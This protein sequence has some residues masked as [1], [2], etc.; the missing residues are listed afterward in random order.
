M[1]TYFALFVIYHDVVR[2]YISV[3][4]SFTVA[5]IQGFEKFKHVISYIEVDELGVQCSEVCIV[6]VFEYERRSFAL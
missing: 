1:R 4:Y 6:D 2:F 3:H 5:E